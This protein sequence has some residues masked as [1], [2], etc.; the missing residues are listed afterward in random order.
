MTVFRSDMDQV[1]FNKWK[2]IWL[3]TF[4]G[5]KVDL[6]VKNIFQFVGKR[7]KSYSYQTIEIN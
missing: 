1:F 4:P 6:S 7:Y 2:V 3:Y 5:N